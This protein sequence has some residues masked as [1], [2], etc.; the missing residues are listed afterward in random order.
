MPDGDVYRSWERDL[1]ASFGKG[2]KL[3]DNVPSSAATGNIYIGPWVDVSVLKNATVNVL[4]TGLTGTANIEGTNLEN[5]QSGTTGY[6]LCTALSASGLSALTSP[7]RY[8][9]AR[10][11]GF[12]AGNVT[13]MYWGIA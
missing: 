9:R 4:G 11:T 6:A 3:L 2:V 10:M 8:I 5:P 12:T 1:V 7:V 13:V